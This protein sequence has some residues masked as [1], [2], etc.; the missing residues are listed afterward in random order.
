[1]YTYRQIGGSKPPK[2]TN[3]L[4]AGGMASRS[5]NKGQSC[6]S[7]FRSW[8]K[9]RRS[10]YPFDRVSAY[11]V[12]ESRSNLEYEGRAAASVAQYLTTKPGYGRA[13]ILVSC[14]EVDKA[15]R[16]KRIPNNIAYELG[17]NLIPALA[18]LTVEGVP[19]ADISNFITSIM[20]KVDRLLNDCEAVRLAT[21]RSIQREYGS[22]RQGRSE[23][24]VLCERALNIA[25]QAV[26]FCR[27]HGVLH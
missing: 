8:M 22:M 24:A 12:R 18:A 6:H 17:Y 19:E 1:M 5:A 25:D 13:G 26:A 14:T 2:P 27:Q 3:H 16:L 4:P 23:M 15:V 10:K 20:P 11:K 21:A 9:M 7:A